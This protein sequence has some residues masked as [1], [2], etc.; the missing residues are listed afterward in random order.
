MRRLTFGSLAIL[1][2]AGA[3]VWYV[4]LGPGSRSHRRVQDRAGLLYRTDIHEFER[5]LT[6][7]QRESGVDIRFILLDS[8]RDETLEE[9]TVRTVRRQGI[10]RD[11]SGRGVL[12]AYEVRGR[13]LRI[14]VGP[15]LL[16]ILT[17]DVVGERMRDHLRSFHEA[18]YPLLGLRLTLVMLQARLRR[19]ALSRNYDPHAA[20]FIKDRSRLAAGL[21]ST[22]ALS[23]LRTSGFRGRGAGDETRRRFAPQPTV[24]AAYRRY[25]DWVRQDSAEVDVPLFTRATQNYLA[26]IHI[27]PAFA[28]YM[29]FLE[30]GRGYEV[31]ERGDLAMLYFTDDPLTAPHFFRR[32]PEGW[33]VDLFADVQHTQEAVGAAWTWSMVERDDDITRAFADRYTKVEAFIRLAG[34]DNRPLPVHWA[35]VSRLLTRPGAGNVPGLERLTV[36]EA[37]QRI[38]AARG[39]PA[40]VLFYKWGNA[41][42]RERFPAI[43]ALLR[44]CRQRGASVLAFSVD[45]QWYAPPKL[46]AFL[47]AQGA[48]FPAIHL[49]RWLEGRFSGAM[50]PLGFDIGTT[51]G[52]PLVALLDRDGQVLAQEESIVDRGP[53]VAVGRIEQA[54][55]SLEGRELKQ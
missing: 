25:L 24:T 45:E 28:D 41:R 54:L 46:P 5:Y 42:T 6:D 51:W 20:E 36:A 44:R 11:L 21:G 55:R 19:A 16:D 49:Y 10:G 50:E 32:S 15:P 34:G 43:L 27:T 1:G 2:L 3:G 29:L 39:R 14:E 31:L 30:S 9:F 35:E 38:A 33:Q 18:G 12:I 4:A 22:V 47:R 8:L 17:D 13:R 7:V 37:A 26:R 40:V 52:T 23:G 53:G 48:P